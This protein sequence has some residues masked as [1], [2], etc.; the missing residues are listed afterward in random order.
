M[1]ADMGIWDVLL[2][3]TLALIGVNLFLR[4]M[5]RFREAWLNRYQ[6]QIESSRKSK[7]DS[8]EGD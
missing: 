5:L 4:I 3:F 6:A 7:N 8:S 1:I 2:W